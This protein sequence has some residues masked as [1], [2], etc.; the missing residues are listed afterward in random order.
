MLNSLW[1]FAVLVCK[2]TTTILVNAKISCA[3]RMLRHYALFGVVVGFLSGKQLHY[4]PIVAAA[5]IPHNCAYIV[6]TILRSVN[7]DIC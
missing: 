2:A 6:I 5:G 7:D 1:H 4:W 3:L